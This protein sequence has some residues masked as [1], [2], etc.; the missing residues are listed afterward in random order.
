M[1]A[2]LWGKEAG[3]GRGKA[4]SMHLFAPEVGMM[5]A[6]AVVATTI[7]HGVGAALA[8][9]YQDRDQVTVAVFGDGATE[10]GAYH[11]SL[12]FASV[13]QLPVI[14]VCENNGL[15]IHS[16]LSARQSYTITDHAR[17]YNL[18][19]VHCAEGYDF[20]RVHQAFSEIA[21][22]VRRTRSPQ[23]I[24]ITTFRYREH[25]GPGEDYDAGYRSRAALEEWQSKDPLVGD[26]ELIT[27]YRP[28]ILREI[29]EAITF[30]EASPGLD[31]RDV[32]TDVI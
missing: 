13:H 5:V 21:D 16:R 8:A 25:V 20:I 7:P 10:E 27:K 28:L 15:A 6:S 2:E 31:H 24:E 14:F 32:L 23:F 19:T 18:P 12:N 30:A 1:F 9:K 3:V 4:G 22:E 11:E 29:D 17:S 26:T